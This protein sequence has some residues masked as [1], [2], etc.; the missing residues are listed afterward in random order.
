MAS[1]AQFGVE[2]TRYTEPKQRSWLQTCLIGCLIVFVFL[3]VVAVLATIWVTH[4][5]RGWASDFGSAAIKQVIDTSELPPQQRQAIGEQVDRVAEAFRSGRL[6]MDQMGSIM[7]KLAKSP[8]MTSL[9]VNAAG[10]EYFAHSELSDA[11][12]AA[13]RDTIRRF[14]AGAVEKK[15]DKAGIDAAMIHIADIEPNGNVRLH[16]NV[17][18]KEL[19]AFLAEAK[20]QADKAGIPDQP[21][22]FD[23]AAEFKK[24][25]DEAM[26]TNP[27]PPPADVPK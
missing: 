4:H 22:T 8:L 27:Q 1:D 24:I 5:W 26:N 17:T 13:G 9:M 19:R 7:E 18:D 10:K 2:G 16:Q 20:A 12:K 21:P 11:E 15:I 23:A 25:V 6:S 14:A 3:I